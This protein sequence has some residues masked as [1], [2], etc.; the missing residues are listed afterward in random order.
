MPQRQDE[1]CLPCSNS[2]ETLRSMSEMER[3]PEVHTSTRDEALFI[4]AVMQ[5]ESRDAPRKSKVD[6]T[7]LRKHEWAPQVST[8]LERQAEFHASTQDETC[9]SC[10]NSTETLRSMSEMERNPEVS[11]S[12]RDE[13]LLIPAETQEE[14]RGPPS[15]SKADLISL[16]KHERVPQVPIQLERNP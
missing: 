8:Q 3:N 12:T 6:L 11:A 2:T 4:C 1:A 9:L 5:E 16:R 15:N 14:S 10:S 7:S 13:A